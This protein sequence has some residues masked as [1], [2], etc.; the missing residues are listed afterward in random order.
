VLFAVEQ[1][2]QCDEHKEG[3]LELIMEISHLSNATKVTSTLMSLVRDD[4]KVEI[5]ITNYR[6]VS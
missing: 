1:V 2:G 6:V 4:G 5:G 3:H